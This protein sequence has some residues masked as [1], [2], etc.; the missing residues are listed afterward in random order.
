MSSTTDTTPLTATPASSS[1]W[2]NDD[3]LAVWIGLLIFLASLAWLYG[4]DVLGWAVTT[5]VWIDPGAALGTV[6]KA[7]A[8]LGGPGALVATY[9]ALVGVLT[10]GVAALRA[11]VLRFV[12]AFTV[13]FVIGYAS[14]IVGS[15]AR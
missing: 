9:L 13:V 14:W 6:S 15:Y 3:W 4:Y 8:D 12:A 1:P 7:Y 2:I 5:S 10:I 11:N